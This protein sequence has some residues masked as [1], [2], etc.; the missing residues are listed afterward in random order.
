MQQIQTARLRKQTCTL[1]VPLTRS[2][3][4]V[5]QAIFFSGCSYEQPRRSYS[6]FISHLHQWTNGDLYILEHGPED[7]TVIL[8]S[9]IAI[10]IYIYI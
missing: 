2:Y 9:V 5:S 7:N 6:E 10:N 1:V 8:Y 4:P 3:L